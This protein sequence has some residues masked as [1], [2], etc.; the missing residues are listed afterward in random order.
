VP[1]EFLQAA[2][3][4]GVL[5]VVLALAMLP[6]QPRASAE[7]VVTV[8]AAVIGGL[9]LLAVVLMVRWSVPRLPPDDKPRAKALNSQ[10][11]TK[12]EGRQL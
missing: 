12:G 8:L 9:F 11:A 6:F 10:S 1:P 4:L 5:I 7:F 2:F 3:R